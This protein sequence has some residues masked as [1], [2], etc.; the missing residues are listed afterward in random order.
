MPI[1][2]TAYTP[3]VAPATY[4]ARVTKC[5]EFAPPKDPTNVFRT[6]EF[7][8]TDGTGRTVKGSSSLSTSPKSKGGKWI[9]ALIGHYLADGETVE[10]VGL[11]CTI[12]VSI[13]DGKEYEQVEAVAPPDAGNKPRAHTPSIETIIESETIDGVEPTVL[14]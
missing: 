11:P 13:P 3:A 10:L 9:N 12:L 8:L 14:P 6:W 2:G 1:T 5:D 4:Q 7:T